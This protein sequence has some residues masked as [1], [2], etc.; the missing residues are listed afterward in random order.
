MKFEQV[1]TNVETVPP[2]LQ[3]GSKLV[4]GE[5]ST[6]FLKLWQNDQLMSR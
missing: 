2:S 6:T 3:L 1:E 5:K 4:I